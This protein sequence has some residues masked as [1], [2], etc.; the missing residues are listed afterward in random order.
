MTNL[1]FISYVNATATQLTAELPLQSLQ[2]ALNLSFSYVSNVGGWMPDSQQDPNGPGLPANGASVDQAASD[3]ATQQ[4]EN[5]YDLNFS[6]NVTIRVQ[7]TEQFGAGL[8]LGDANA[9]MQND[10]ATFVTNSINNSALP[11]RVDAI[12]SQTPQA[13]RSM[14]GGETTQTLRQNIAADA[15]DNIKI[16]DYKASAL[17]YS[18]TVNGL[19]DTW[20]VQYVYTQPGNPVVV[21]ILKYTDNTY[22]SIDTS[23]HTTYVYTV[24]PTTYQIVSGVVLTS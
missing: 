10:L 12:L 6:M 20:N 5:V 1:D 23:N 7:F 21:I 2:S 24:S 15:T 4:I 19:D 17:R 9:A 13:D 8:D 16:V 22:A 14:L 11:I 3:I 18:T